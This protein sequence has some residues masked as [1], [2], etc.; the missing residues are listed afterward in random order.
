MWRSSCKL[1]FAVVKAQTPLVRFVVE[2]RNKLKQVEFEL[3]KCR[4]CLDL[5]AYLLYDTDAEDELTHMRR[6]TVRSFARH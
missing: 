6:W 1:S 5:L 2:I 4:K 3:N